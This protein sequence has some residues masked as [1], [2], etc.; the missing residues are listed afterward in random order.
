MTAWPSRRPWRGLSTQRRKHAMP[1]RPRSGSEWLPW[2]YALVAVPLVLLLI[3]VLRG[4]V[5]DFTL[6]RTQ[7]VHSQLQGLQ[8]QALR[9]VTG[10]EVL[11]AA[12]APDETSW[13]QI[14][15]EPWLAGYW[16]R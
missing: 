5:P 8:S 2:A 7:T 10:I 6:I 11:L 1:N 12:H 4:A 3:E 14:R 16:S 13:T 9:R 15:T